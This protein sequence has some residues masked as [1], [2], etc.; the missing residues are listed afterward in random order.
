[1]GDIAVLLLVLG[2]YWALQ[3]YI[4]PKMGVPT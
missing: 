2:G 1:M 4:L 3:R